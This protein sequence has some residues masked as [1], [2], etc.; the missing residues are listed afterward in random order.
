[1][2]KL[3]KIPLAVIA[4][5]CV[6]SFQSRQVSLSPLGSISSITGK[7][8]KSN[9]FAAFFKWDYVM[10][11]RYGRTCSPGGGICF[12]NEDGEYF[13]YWNY[14]VAPGDVP[15]DDATDAEAGPMYLRVEGDRLHVVFC[16]SIEGDRFQ[17][18]ED[19]R[20]SDGL[21]NSL[22]KKF[23]IKKGEYRVDFNQY[24]E[25]GESWLNIY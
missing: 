10:D 4:L 17:V 15:G 7:E 19:V 20:L 14:S 9:P 5:L 12:H 24:K 23:T 22:G 21:Q 18:D 25:Y 2:I 6:F 16:R 13:D 11:W 8:F 3:L 1:M